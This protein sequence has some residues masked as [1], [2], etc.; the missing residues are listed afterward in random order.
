M[1]AL[2]IT[3]KSKDNPKPPV[4]FTADTIEE[5]TK[6]LILE[7]VALGYDPSVF[8]AR[9]LVNH[10][11]RFFGTDYVFFLRKAAWNT[12]APDAFWQ[13]GTLRDAIDRVMRLDNPTGTAL[14]GESLWKQYRDFEAEEQADLDGSLI[15][16]HSG[17]YEAMRAVLTDYGDGSATLEGEM[18]DYEDEDARADELG[19]PSSAIDSII[20]GIESDL[21]EKINEY[22]RDVNDSKRRYDQALRRWWD[23]R[24]IDPAP[25]FTFTQTIPVLR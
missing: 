10:K 11:I 13:A 12:T 2:T 15:D 19:D 25:A 23:E 8:A 21:R 5:A 7:A 22:N 1:Y 14:F 24:L 17:V 9:E 18:E 3:D 4:T 6:T 20:E 16:A